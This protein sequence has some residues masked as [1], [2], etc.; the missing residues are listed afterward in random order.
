[1]ENTKK[2][3][4]RKIWSITTTVLVVLIVVSALFLMGARI[5]GLRVYTVLSGSMKPTYNPGDLIYV[6][7][8]DP[9]EIKVGDPITFVMNE[10]LVVATHRVVDI[11]YENQRFYTKGDGNQIADTNPVHFKNLIGKPLF[12]IPYLG[13]ISSWVQSP[14]GIYVAIGAGIMLIG[15]VFIPDLFHS[16]KEEELRKK[17]EELNKRE[18]ELKNLEK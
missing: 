5:V 8:V 14:P 11:D 3:V 17:E 4:G 18:E 9:E 7:N 2:S 15:I 10:N 12:H 1:M 13:Y 16:A 6:K